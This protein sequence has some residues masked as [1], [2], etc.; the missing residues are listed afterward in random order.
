[1]GEIIIYEPNLTE[2]ENEKN[3]KELC[4][5]VECIL[6]SNHNYQYKFVVDI[7]KLNS[8]CSYESILI[9]KDVKIHNKIGKII[10]IEKDAFYRVKL[11][12]D[13]QICYIPIENIEK[14]L[15]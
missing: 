15:I 9:N 4:G 5:I 7:E 14:Y 12:E 2:E 11:I 3:L 13:N 10:C 8:K 1:M 6:E